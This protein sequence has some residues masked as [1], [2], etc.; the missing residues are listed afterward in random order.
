MEIC[1][2]LLL[3]YPSKKLLDSQDVAHL[4]EAHDNEKNTPLHIAARMNNKSI[5]KCLLKEGNKLKNYNTNKRNEDYV[6]GVTVPLNRIGRTPLHEC[7]KYNRKSF[8]ELLLPRN[9]NL[10]IWETKLNTCK[11]DDQMTCLHLASSQGK[12]ETYSKKINHK[13]L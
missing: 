4:L 6:Y 12:H 2:T 1:K 7:A 3:D 8:I 11:D 10:R 9:D 5:F 13:I